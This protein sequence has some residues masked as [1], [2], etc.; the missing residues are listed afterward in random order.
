MH[1]YNFI[2]LYNI[3]YMLVW[4][5]RPLDWTTSTSYLHMHACITYNVTCIQQFALGLQ[6]CVCMHLGQYW[7]MYPWPNIVHKL[8]HIGPQ[9]AKWAMGHVDHGPWPTMYVWA[10]YTLQSRVHDYH[11]HMLV[12][13]ILQTFYM[14]LTLN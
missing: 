9:W 1:I 8:L 14:Q 10:M 3:I 6:T 11:V 5:S 4:H 12:A 2:I 13:W 7:A